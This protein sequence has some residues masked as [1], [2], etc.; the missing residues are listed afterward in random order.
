MTM[1]HL[2][3][4]AALTAVLVLVGLATVRFLPA[5]A[6]DDRK[7]ERA[8]EHG[9]VYDRCARACN[10]CQRSCDACATHCARLL[11][12]GR[13]HHIRTLHEC[14]DCAT[15]CSAAAQVV[16]REGPFADLICQ[17]CA[18]ACERC[19]KACAEH[20]DDRIMKVCAEECR[21]CERACREMLK[22]TEKSRTDRR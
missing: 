17:S 18:S 19:A 16:A 20:R 6:G 22:H 1:R 11:A 5:A 13:K 9:E 7:G 15:V 2:S 3:W 14:Q 4:A 10:E 21:K 8:A 12:E